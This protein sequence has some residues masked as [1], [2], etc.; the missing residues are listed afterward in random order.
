MVIPSSRSLATKI[1]FPGLQLANRLKTY[2][3]IHFLNRQLALS[4]VGVARDAGADGVFLISHQGDDA[5]LIDVAQQARD[6][7]PGFPIGINLLSRSA[8][9]AVHATVAHGLPMVW[10]DDMGVSS[11]GLS[12]EG[13]RLAALACSYPGLMFFASVAFKYQA[14]EPR[15]DEAARQALAAGFLPTTS[16]AGTGQAPDVGKVASM[17]AAAGGLLA[18]A[19]GMTPENIATFAPYLSHCLVATGIG[20]DEHRIDF[21]KLVRFIAASRRA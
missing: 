2:P 18:V 7:H 8:E 3:V 4:E 13:V 9:D 17:S 5:T 1:V 15:P 20:H 10:A 14:P 16:G 11:A 19:S 6:A 12:Q 21:E